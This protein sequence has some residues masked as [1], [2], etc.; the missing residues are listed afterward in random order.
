MITKSTVYD[1]QKRAETVVRTK[2]LKKETYIFL[3]NHY[4]H[5]E[6]TRGDQT[7]TERT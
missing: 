4:Y 5:D 6:R 2:T 3:A 1:N 7:K